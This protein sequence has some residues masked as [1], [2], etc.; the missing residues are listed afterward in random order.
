MPDEEIT[1]D[2]T[3]DRVGSFL[4]PQ[5]APEAFV[6]AAARPD[7][8]DNNLMPPFTHRIGNPKFTH[9]NLAQAF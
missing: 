7:L 2:L 8:D 6:E 3:Q 5:S 9:L 4:F 1:S